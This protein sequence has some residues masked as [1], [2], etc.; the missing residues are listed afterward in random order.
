MGMWRTAERQ[1]R[2]RRS[3]GE[4][5]VRRGAQ[6]DA[7]DSAP[8]T[9]DH[10]LTS[11]GR[12]GGLRRRM[13][14]NMKALLLIAGCCLAL[15]TVNVV[16]ADCPKICQTRE[17]WGRGPGGAS[18]CQCDDG[19]G[20]NRTGPNGCSCGVCY[21]NE[22]GKI[23]AYGYASGKCSFGTDCG[24]SDCKYDD[25]TASPTTTAPPSSRPPPTESPST[26]ALTSSSP[27]SP[28]STPL[29]PPAT[30]SAA[31]GNASVP[32]TR[33]PSTSSPVDSTPRPSPSST[34]A[35]NGHSGSLVA[36]G[37]AGSPGATKP[38]EGS[39][40]KDS[41]KDSDS[42]MATWQIALIICS[43]VLVF[44]VAM[45]TLMSC[46][47]KTRKEME[48]NETLED[49]RQMYDQYW[50]AKGS[51]DAGMAMAANDGGNRGSF[52]S[53]H[54]RPGST[55]QVYNDAMHADYAY[56]NN[57]NERIGGGAI[58]RPG[59]GS[60]GSTSDLPHPPTFNAFPVRDRP[61]QEVGSRKHIAIE[62]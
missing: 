26:P 56:S 44:A 3:G 57:Y 1:R 37:T 27:S 29:S 15:T 24:V 39:T 4:Q 60:V 62:L 31:A 50:G 53:T 52:A 21:Q 41:K 47:C 33:L 58:V 48:E 9:S 7:Q 10:G 43:A 2:G 46:Y 40:E 16:A 17:L 36:D 22:N 5:G 45:M 11:H 28:P 34:H 49:D 18:V 35:P 61:S 23:V 30:S 38:A 42:G 59:R 25:S 13:H 51:K 8:T 12:S 14:A 54:S 6:G 19:L 32:P 20:P 55:K